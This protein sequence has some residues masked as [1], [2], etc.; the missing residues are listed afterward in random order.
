[1]EVIKDCGH[2][3]FIEKKAK[4]FT[5]VNTFV[6]ENRI[7]GAHLLEPGDVIGLGQSVRLEFVAPQTAPPPTPAVTAEHVQAAPAPAATPVSK[8]DLAKTTLGDVLPTFDPGGL[9]QLS[10]G[11]SGNVPEVYTLTKNWITF[12]RAD[13]NDI[14]INSPLV[15]RKHGHLEKIAT[16]S[17]QLV[18]EPGAGNPVFLDGRKVT[19]PAQMHHNSKLR[20]G[21][22]DPG[23]LVS[24]EYLSPSEAALAAPEEITFG[25]KT[26]IQI[27]R[28]ASNDVILNVSQVSRYNTQLE[29][30]GKRYKVKD[31]GSTNGTFVND[32]RITEEVWL[33]PDDSVR[34]GPYRFVMG[35]ESLIQFDDSLNL[36]V[37]AIELNKWVRED[38]NILQ[39]ISLVLQPREFIVVVGQSGGGKSTLVDAIAG[40]RP[41]THGQVFVND[42]NVYENFDYIRDIIGFVPQ[43]DIIHMELTVFDAL[44]YTA[45]LRMPRDTTTDERHAR[46]ME[47]LDDLDIAHRKDN[48]ISAISGGQQKRVSIGVELLTKPGLF[49]LDEP[50]SGLDPGT[51]TALMHLMRQMADQGRTII[52]ITH[53]TKNVVLADKVVFL[54]RG[55]HLVWFGPPDEAL[56]Y[57]DKYRSDRDQRASSMEFDQIY[58]LLEDEAKGSPAEW[59]E[60]YRQNKAYQENIVEPLSTGQAAAV[61]QQAAP[62]AVEASATPPKE[63]E[64]RASSWRQFLILSKRNIRI[65]TRDRFSLALMLA[66]SP[67]VG[68]LSVVLAA[69][70][71]RNPF[72]FN[73]GDPTAI[74]ITLFMLT[75]YG[76]MVGGL[77]QMREIVKEGDIYKRER[78][79]NL[80]I[81]PYVLSKVWV[82]AVLAMYQAATYTII[83][84]LAFD[85]PGGTLEFGLVFISL[86]FATMAGMMLGLFAS[87][88]APNANAAPLI[89]IMFMLPQ[90]VL[91]GALV[92]LPET[93]S[94]IT[95]T[96]WAFQGLIAITGVGSDISSDVCWAL[97]PEQRAAMTEEDKLET[98]QCLGT[99]ALR[100]GSCNFP[101]LGVYYNPEIDKAPPPDL[102]PEPVRPADPVI[103]EPPLEPE[104]QSD[105]VAMAAYFAEL[106][107]WQVVAEKVQADSTAAF[108]AYE[109]EIVVFQAEVVAYQEALITHRGSIIAAVQ[110]AEAIVG[111][112]A[113]DL[114]WA[115]VDKDDPAVFWPFL[116]KTWVAQGVIIGILF[117]GILIL[118]KRKDVN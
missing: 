6:N 27:G 85:M 99:N 104:D 9:Q 89:V 59:A 106:Q 1:M 26:V 92:P 30:I 115:F 70:L 8:E 87:A 88:L 17:Y 98:C 71:G 102:G 114:G 67:I 28:D 74:I 22:Q 14:V 91:G 48:Q 108:A 45:Q 95:S 16:G 44:D 40:Y 117:V 3:P 5:I 21:G 15:S 75:V 53:A 2:F 76:V 51:E 112:F 93:I 13:D 39:N 42:T 11:I 57:F 96:K 55:G 38:L 69:V 116:I 23:I 52:L 100:E 50:S 49:L 90:I 4:F 84:Y 63:P 79:V 105:S 18:I 20:I 43:K 36:R 101:G 12:G 80:K 109:A 78:L 83:H 111:T 10:V 29:R 19:Q 25:E 66:A 7:S 103:P 60:R 41:A 65:L 61:P 97:T 86:A 47:V 33:N 107:E 81:F 37:R 54:A 94:G 56:T 82:A 34:I 118:Q 32:Q 110:P 62:V 77:S 64:K 68:M 31:L 46:V 35:T 58:A 72:D 73:E 24:M 113:R